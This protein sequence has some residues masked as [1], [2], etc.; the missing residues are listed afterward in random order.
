MGDDDDDG[1]GAILTSRRRN[2][3]HLGVGWRHDLETIHVDGVLDVVHPLGLSSLLLPFNR[4]RLRERTG[5]RRAC[6][7][8]SRSLLRRL[9]QS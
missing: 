2:P 6:W 4:R 3:G 1:E 7:R 8:P 9:G 5:P